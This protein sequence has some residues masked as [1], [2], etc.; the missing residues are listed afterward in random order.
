MPTILKIFRMVD[1]RHI[2]IDLFWDIF[3]VTLLTSPL[4][5]TAIVF[6][7]YWPRKGDYDEE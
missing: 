4:W 2:M 3:A 6:Y 1:L 5:F 7:A